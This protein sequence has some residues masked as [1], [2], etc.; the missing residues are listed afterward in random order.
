MRTKL[1]SAGLAAWRK[2][3]TAHALLIEQIDRD[4]AAA[5]CIPLQ[6]YDVLVELLEAPEQRLRM[7]ELARRVVLSR[8]TLTHLAA[9]LEG[10]G[11][12]RRE[13]VDTDRRGAYAVLTDDGREAMR[14]AWPVY[15]H[16][17]AG[18]FAAHLSE[19]EADQLRDLLARVLTMNRPATDGQAGTREEP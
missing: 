1:S 13:R 14:K 15:A 7:S 6:W 4:L 9:R 17:I 10:E 2:L 5:G 3:I 8:S 12:L 18:Y 11:L 19:E 16:G